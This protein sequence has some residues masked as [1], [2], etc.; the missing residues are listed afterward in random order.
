MILTLSD[1]MINPKLSCDWCQKRNKKTDIF[2]KTVAG[3]DDSRLKSRER[4]GWTRLNLL[5]K[6]YNCNCSFVSTG[7][8]K[9]RDLNSIPIFDGIGENVLNDEY[10][11]V[12]RMNTLRI[13]AKIANSGFLLSLPFVP[14]ELEQDLDF[15][16]FP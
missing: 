1:H 4:S 10:F 15:I 16:N 3:E 11:D 12:F 8:D 7:I 14:A 9:S 13:V 6:I 2:P 5:W